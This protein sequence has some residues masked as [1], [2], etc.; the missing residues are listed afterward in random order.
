MKRWLIVGFFFLS[1]LFAACQ[2]NRQP[3]QAIPNGDPERGVA[4]IQKYGCGSC[5]TID[6]VPGANAR[7]GPPLSGVGGR[8]YIAGR[9]A[10][11]PDNLVN[12]I[13]HPQE[14]EPG[15]AMP[16]MGVNLQDAQDIAAYLYTLY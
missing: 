13:Q 12:W 16:D 5:H 2:P 14:I 3:I 8:A 1:S 6:G 11:K 4:A 15:V 7:V 10:N 9:L